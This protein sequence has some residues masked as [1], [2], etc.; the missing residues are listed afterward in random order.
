MDFHH[1]FSILGDPLEVAEVTPLDPCH[2]LQ[3]MPF[4]IPMLCAPLDDNA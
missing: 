4:S 2:Y 1:Y 3:G